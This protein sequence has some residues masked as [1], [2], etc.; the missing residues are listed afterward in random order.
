[1]GTGFAYAY[2]LSAHTNHWHLDSEIMLADLQGKVSITNVPLDVEL[3]KHK[4]FVRKQ[5]NFRRCLLLLV[6]ILF[7]V[8]GTIAAVLPSCTRLQCP[9]F[10][11]LLCILC[12]CSAIF[13]RRHPGRLWLKKGAQ[14]IVA[15]FAIIY[16]T[17]LV[18]LTSEKTFGSSYLNFDFG[19]SGCFGNTTQYVCSSPNSYS[20]TADDERDTFNTFGHTWQGFLSV[21]MFEDVTQIVKMWLLALSERLSCQKDKRRLSFGMFERSY[22]KLE[23][24]IRR[25]TDFLLCC[26]CIYP[27]Y[28]LFKRLI[29]GGFDNFS[30]SSYANNGFEWGTGFLF[31]IAVGIFSSATSKF[32]TNRNVTELCRPS[33]EE[34]SSFSSLPKEMMLTYEKQVDAAMR[35]D[36]AWAMARTASGV[37]LIICG[38]IAVIFYALSWGIYSK[39]RFIVVMD[40]S[41]ALGMIIFV[42]ILIGLFIL[43]FVTKQEFE[44]SNSIS[45]FHERVKSMGGGQGSFA[46]LKEANSA[47]PSP[48]VTSEE[49]ELT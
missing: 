7:F 26:V 24:L 23:I 47:S 29:K 12:A 3:L 40:D 1:M 33:V 8:Q 45:A 48:T 43:P 34:G 38:I 5:I 21:F 9:F 28:N 49:V 19:P 15:S 25:T 10:S 35:E 14:L 16:I 22:Q 46:S 42:P 20:F 44:T 4:P 2:A 36:R 11:F 13:Y 39:A 6:G 17:L 30:T 41:V 18:R 32:V 27:C 31:G 37:L